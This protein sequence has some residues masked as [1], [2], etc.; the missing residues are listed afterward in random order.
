MH[1]KNPSIN[2]INKLGVCLYADLF[3]RGNIL[4][5][6]RSY[7]Y[8]AILT[9]KATHIRFPMI[10]KSKNAICDRSKIFFNNVET[11]RRRKMQYFWLDNIE[12]YQ[13]LVPYFKEKGII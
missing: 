1:S 3:D 7:Q 5:D 11:Y 6:V 8:G 13:L 4:P 10:I 9:D 12:K 2:I